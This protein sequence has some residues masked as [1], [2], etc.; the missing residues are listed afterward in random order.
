MSE[1]FRNLINGEWKDSK[2]GE[3]FENRNPA[4]WKDDLIGTV[5]IIGR[6][7]MWMKP[8]KLQDC[9]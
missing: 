4:N 5:S 9:I 2:K 1:K 8:S 3:T 7:R 6:K